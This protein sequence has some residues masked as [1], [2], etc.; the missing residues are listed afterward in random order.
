MGWPL[1]SLNG[2]WLASAAVDCSLTGDSLTVVW[3]CKITFF[4]TMAIEVRQQDYICEHNFET[5]PL[6]W[7]APV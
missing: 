5:F 7:S 4:N 6:P 1:T 2:Q 3:P